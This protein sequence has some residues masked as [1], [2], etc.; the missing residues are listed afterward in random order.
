[1]AAGEHHGPSELVERLRAHAGERARLHR[2]DLAAEGRSRKSRH[3]L[4]RA[5]VVGAQVVVD[6]HEHLLGSEAVVEAAQLLGVA[7]VV[8]VQERLRRLREPRDPLAA[9]PCG[10]QFDRALEALRRLDVVVDRLEVEGAQEADG[11]AEDGDDP[12]IGSH[13]RDPLRR[14][15]R[16]QVLGRGLAGALAGRRAREQRQVVVERLGQAAR[17]ERAKRERSSGAK[18]R[19]SF[20]GM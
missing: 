8:G 14:L 10:L 18:N 2:H 3:A 15:R 17:A 12:G 5:G 9:A 1:M 7:H 16:A 4:D 20:S 19:G 11:L 6:E 13:R